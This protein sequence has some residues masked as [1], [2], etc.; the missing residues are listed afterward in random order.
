MQRKV[1][2]LGACA[3]LVGLGAVAL[4]VAALVLGTDYSGINGAVKRQIDKV[5]A[6]YYQLVR[7]HTRCSFAHVVCDARSWP[8]LVRAAAEPH[9]TSVEGF[10]L[11]QPDQPRGVCRGRQAQRHSSGPLQLQVSA[12]D[13]HQGPPIICVCA[14][15]RVCVQCLC[16]EYRS[17]FFLSTS[18]N[19]TELTYNQ[20]KLFFWDNSTSGPDLEEEDVI[21]T[22]NIPLLV[23]QTLEHID[24]G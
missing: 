24:C 10:L 18:P 12:C 17:K 5:G 22:I 14:C 19:G 4:L 15:V 7:S 8:R 11:L 20:S 16:R 6:L 1:Y 2:C 21:C 3:S 9:S 13:G 23:S